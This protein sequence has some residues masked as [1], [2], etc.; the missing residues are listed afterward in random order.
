TEKSGLGRSFRETHRDPSIREQAHEAPEDVGPQKE[1]DTATD[2]RTRQIELL[3]E[4][5]L[6]SDELGDE[7]QHH[8]EEECET[9]G[10]RGHDLPLVSVPRRVRG[11]NAPL[12]TGPALRGLTEQGRTH[13]S[14][15]LW[16]EVVAHRT[17]FV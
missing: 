11:N 12:G 15:G 14:Q 13:V 9:H 2:D 16:W 7:Q 3:G 5:P 10:V 8:Q 17:L 6:D 4:L 1:R